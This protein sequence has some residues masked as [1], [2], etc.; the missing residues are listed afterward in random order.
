[1]RKLLF[2]SVL[3]TLALSAIAMELLAADNSLPAFGQDTVLVWKLENQGFQAEF[4]VRIAEFAPDRFLEWEDSNSQ[5][6]I[7]MPVQDVMSAKGFSSSS[8]FSSGMDTRGRDATTL[9]LSRKIYLE[10]KE[11]KKTKCNLD[12]VSGFLTYQG[13]GD[14]EV[15]V[16]RK[17]MTLPVIKVSDDRG[18]ERWFLDQEGNPLLLKH[19]VHKFTQVLTSITTDRPN[20]LRWIKGRKLTNLPK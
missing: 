17:S 16:N 18:G 4:V 8:L 13:N 20:T 5:G 14:I 7:F 9:W 1:M 12:G 2:G 11:K 15:E 19:S 6:T 10:L 3:I